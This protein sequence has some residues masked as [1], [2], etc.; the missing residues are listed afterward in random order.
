MI[1][2]E[3]IM[4]NLEYKTRYYELCN[5][6]TK[7]INISSACYF[8]MQDTED[9]AEALLRSMKIKS[10]C[11]MDYDKYYSVEDLISAIKMLK[12]G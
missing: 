6:K 12:E 1:R 7:L 5:S 11:L 3:V 2:M 9:K 10:V 4:N 8:V